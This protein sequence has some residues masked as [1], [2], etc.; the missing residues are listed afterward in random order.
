M[1]ILP[2]V[3]V[4]ALLGW[5]AS[6][7]FAATFTVINTNDSGPGSLRQAI[8]DANATPGADTIAFNIPGAGVR[9]ISP[10]SSLPAL[11]DDTGT[12]INGY[13]QP[14]SAPNTL[15]VGDN[16]SL[17]IEVNGASAGPFSI[18]ITLQSP[19]NSVRG[20]VINQFHR[21]VSIQRSQNSVAGCFLGMDPDGS[22]ARGNRIGVDLSMDSATESVIVPPLT[23]L[24]IGGTDPASRNVISG[25]LESG[26]GGFN[27]ADSL[28]EGNYIG[29]VKSGMAPLG[30]GGYG[31]VF[32]FS[33]MVTIGGGTAGAGNLIS[34][35]IGAGIG[36]GPTSHMLIQGNL[37]GTNATGS[38]T[39]SNVIGIS[40]AQADG[41]KIGGASA[42]EGNIISGNDQDGIILANSRN[43]VVLGNLIGTDRSGLLP[44]PNFR[45]G[46]YIYALST[47]HGIGGQGPGERNVIAFNAASGIGI[48]RDVLD[49]SAGNRVSGNSI[50]G[51][52]GLG[53]DLASDGSTANDS[54]DGDAGPNNLQNFPVL[55]AA[56]SNGVSTGVRGSLNSSPATSFTIEFFAS[57]VCDGSG[58]GEGHTFLGAT[59]VTTD[60]SGNAA[61]DVT[62]PAPSVGQVVTATATD[63]AGNTSEFSACVTVMGLPSPS[64]PVP[65]GWPVLAAL[66]VLLAGA[67]ALLSRG[68]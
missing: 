45:R 43:Y 36:L 11:T 22:S 63:A 66:G 16:A 44:V 20:L 9:T 1:R 23:N 29:T 53:I 15:A 39:V 56:T 50:H 58:N 47:G 57:P 41:S 65:L 40:T 25:N 17:L 32:G 21:G 33:S 18:G 35:N 54:A 2:T 5:G 49:M 8:L 13:T 61:I 34:G 19:S 37:I 60:G 51:N 6:S 67:G 31:V 30:N 64:A 10:L 42:G 27:I 48:G 46:I 55:S 24:I 3:A 59:A 28:V 4:A 62:L 38:A 52:G 7:A 68:R 26:V 14:G 12:T